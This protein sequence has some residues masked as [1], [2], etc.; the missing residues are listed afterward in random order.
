VL[1]L[2]RIDEYID[3]VC[4]QIRNK[5]AHKLIKNE[6][7]NHI[8]DQKNAFVKQ[9][10]DEQTALDKAIKEMGDPVSVGNQFDKIHKTKPEWSIIFFT[11][12][13]IIINLA[14]NILISKDRNLI[15][16]TVLCKLFISAILGI[17]LLS[18]LYFIDYSI[19]A[20]YSKILLI[21]FVIV[22]VILNTNYYIAKIFSCIIILAVPLY[23]TIVYNLKGK[24]YAG[25]IIS[26]LG[27]LVITVVFLDS[28]VSYVLLFALCC[29]IILTVSTLKGWF[30]IKYKLFTVLCGFIIL[31]VP[32]VF[33]L[34]NSPYRLERLLFIINPYKDPLGAGYQCVITKEVLKHSQLIG[35]FEPFDFF[36]NTINPQNITGFVPEFEDLIITYL[37]SKFGFIAGI[38]VIG[39]FAILIARIF[40]I[41]F[42]QKSTL[43]FI[44]SFSCI[45]A[46]TMQTINYIT[47]NL[48][49]YLLSSGLPLIT[50]GVS[51]IVNMCLI[52]ILLS[53]FKNDNLINC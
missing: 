48:G 40:K 4:K 36:N 21:A 34:I 24:G 9:G 45:L 6:L 38:F 53:V 28:F 41:C 27:C 3:N 33:V 10:L 25:I 51:L 18:A 37:I 22:G 16:S 32:I 50:S 49:F 13:M 15:D 52:G 23:A 46:I 19:I 5:K 30:N 39:M 42:N 20:K 11:V 43:G 8:I 12:V 47:F 26:A 35:A 44:V 7:E 1:I 17:A 29:I 14:V 31:F 2:N